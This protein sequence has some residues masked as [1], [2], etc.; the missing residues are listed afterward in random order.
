MVTMPKALDLTAID[1]VA[2]AGSPHD[3]VYVSRRFLAQVYAEL[4]LSRTQV[5]VLDYD[6]YQRPAN[7]YTPPLS[8]VV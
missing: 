5:A 4:H 7:T 8:P 3:G 2:S 1:R 6:H